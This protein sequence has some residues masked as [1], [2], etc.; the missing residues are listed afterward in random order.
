MLIKEDFEK[1]KVGFMFFLD[2]R[3]TV[4]ERRKKVDH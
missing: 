3:A 2:L 1:M 4:S